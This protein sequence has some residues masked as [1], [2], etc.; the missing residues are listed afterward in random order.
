MSTS[1]GTERGAAVVN[2]ALSTWREGPAKQAILAFIAAICGE[3]GSEPVPVE[4]R[5]AVFDNDGTLW[6]EKPVPIQ[7]DFILRR[8]VEMA[9]ADPALHDRQPWKAARERDRAWFNT[10]M[11][12]HYAGDDRNVRT[13]AAGV[14]AAYAGVSVEDFEAQAAA[15][16]RG[17]QHP[18]LRRGYLECAYAPMVELL[19]F[20]ASN[21]FANYIVSGGGRDF[22]RPIS[23]EVYGIPRERVIGSATALAYD[24]DESGG[25]IT[26]A[27][28]PDYLDDGPEKPIRIWSR[29]GRR[30]LLAA[31]NTN[32]D[33]Q[34]LDFSQHPD[35]QSLRLLILHDDAE[36]EFDYTTGAEQALE[37]AAREQW[38]VVSID[39]DWASVFRA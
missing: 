4:E 11:M 27:P 1:A 2:G 38:T 31:G 25:T 7:M 21:G 32:G 22:M 17:T 29:T 6:C 13:L 24:S 39:N 19:A 3:D 5:V 18:T 36:R 15:F 8:F 10:V 28:A 26:H 23:Q 33:L 34:M 37:Q 20:L 9:E 14:L 12:E 30:P 35:K 16:L